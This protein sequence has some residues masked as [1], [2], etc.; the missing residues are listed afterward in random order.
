MWNIFL[1]WRDSLWVGLVLIFTSSEGFF[2]GKE[3]FN[4][5]VN[6]NQTLIHVGLS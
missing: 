3:L 6:F 1:S 4:L 5:Q 2:L